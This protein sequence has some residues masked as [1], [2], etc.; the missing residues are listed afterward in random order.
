MITTNSNKIDITGLTTA[1]NLI[2]SNPGGVGTMAGELGGG[3][4]GMEEWVGGF[5]CLLVEHEDVEIMG[6]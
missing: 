3:G 2:L 4:G 5:L 1:S 6:E